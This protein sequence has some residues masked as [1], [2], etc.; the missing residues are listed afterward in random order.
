MFKDHVVERLPT[1]CSDDMVELGVRYDFRQVK[2]SL[3]DHSVVSNV[4]EPVL[5]FNIVKTEVYGWWW[6]GS[7]VWLN[8]WFS[9]GSDFGFL[10]GLLGGSLGFSFVSCVHHG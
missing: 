7:R 3:L 8:R 1:S 5:G 4:F 2:P 6:C 9:F 10:D